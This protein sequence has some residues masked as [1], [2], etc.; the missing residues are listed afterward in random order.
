MR[1]KYLMACLLVMIAVPAFAHGKKCVA[2]TELTGSASYFRP[3]GG[4]HSYA[5]GGELAFPL[6]Q[7]GYVYLGPAVSLRDNGPEDFQAIGGV[8]QFVFTGHDGL[9]AE[10]VV[11]YDPDAPQGADSHTLDVRAGFKW[12]VNKGGMIKVYGQKTVDG[13]GKSEDFSAAGAIGLRF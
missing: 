4:R 8:V 3:D 1:L 13:F 9:F 2:L 10:G 7:G 11:L 6:F 12:G 5:V